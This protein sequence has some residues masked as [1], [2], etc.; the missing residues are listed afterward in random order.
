[1]DIIDVLVARAITPQGQIE[2]YA[3]MAQQAVAQ[4]NQAVSD[5][6]TITEQTEQ[7]NET[8]IAT[9]DLATQAL[10]DAQEAVENVQQ[11]LD[12]LD[13][14]DAVA[15]EVKKLLLSVTSVSGQ[16]VIATNLVTTYP[17]NSTKTISNMIKYYTTTGDNEDGTM[18]QK[19]ITAAIAA[20]GQGGSGGGSGSA[21]NLGPENAGNIVVVGEDGTITA[22]DTT[23]ADII[24]ALVK[25]GSYTA[26]NAVGLTID[27]ENKTFTR[28]QEAADYSAG[29]DFS[30]GG[31]YSMYKRMRCNVR[32]NGQITAWYGDSNYKEDGS[33]GQVMVY[34]PKFY[35]QR[36]PL[37][38]ANST[39][40]QAIR[41]ESIIISDTAQAGFKLHP[42]FIDA[43]GHILEYV[44][45]PAYE[46]CSYSMTNNA[47]D[48][49]DSSS[50]DFSK[51]KLSSIAGAKPI[52]G[53]NKNL[54][55]QNAEQL[56]T[57]RGRGWHITNLA[58]ESANQFLELV[59]FGTLNAQDAL[60][61]GIS[62][63]PNNTT[64]N[65]ASLTGSTS[66]LG[67][68]TG[69][70]ESTIN[71]TAGATTTYNVAGRRA[72]SY[73]GM[74]NAWGNIWHM[75][76]GLKIVGTGTSQG[77]TPYI[78]NFNYNSESGYEDVGFYLPTTYDYIS[79]FGY[80][81]SDYDWV[82][83]PIECSGGNSAVP[84]GD[85]IWTT[86]RL[87]GT[88]LAASGGAWS[89]G[90][91]NGAFSYS[92]DIDANQTTRSLNARLMYIPI[93]ASTI[94]TDNYNQWL[95]RVTK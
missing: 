77:G 45:L 54:T 28:T 16:N 7:N 61:L 78:S 47:Y 81:N 18:T 17:D 64:A 19:A 41:R 9:M 34:Q 84:V 82:F 85:Y 65:C 55:I 37:K 42:L 29:T 36:V 50:V 27:Y 44:L 57:N 26:K 12:N 5:I 83:L 62:N 80:G 39:R 33:N 52:S 30:A 93:Y 89:F 11:A 53:N 22:G 92:F 1:M 8:A 69:A 25:S 76:G 68:D 3:A 24:D 94:Y 20:A 13:V 59:E 75:I 15:D 48:L 40:G 38:L 86:A 6:N 21:S 58:A 88:H 91:R 35:Y 70:A 10:A 32:D 31:K 14:S 87:N 72:I 43:N 90:D 46:G 74:E 56:A 51:D 63:I 66:A 67:N 95:G 23:E 2:S 71:E 60:E 4:A 73:R 79:S 49:N